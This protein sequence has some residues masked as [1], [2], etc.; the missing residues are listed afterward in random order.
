MEHKRVLILGKVWPEPNSSAAGRRMV[1]LITMLQEFGYEISF[2]TTAK[3]T[4]FHS[5]PEGIS[6][7]TIAVNDDNVD[8]WLRTLNPEIVIFDRFMTEEQFGWRVMEVLPDALRILNTEDLHFLR[9]AREK[10]IKQ[11]V[12]FENID[13]YTDK[14]KREIAAIYRCD[15]TLM[16]SE[17]EIE[18]LTNTFRIDPSLF[19]YLPLF[20]EYKNERLSFEERKGFVFI[21]N[22][23]HTP[24]WDALQYLKA[25][26]WPLIRAKDKTAV[27][28][29]YGAYPSEKV[30]Q[31][32]KPQEGFYVEGRA[33]DAREVIENARVMLAPIR[34][35]AGMKGKLLEAMELGTPSIVTPIAAEDMNSENR[36]NG[37]ITSDP[38]RLAQEAV[39]LY[40]DKDRW[41]QSQKTGEELIK[42]RYS[43]AIYKDTFRIELE[44]LLA[45]YKEYRKEN[46]MGQLI[47]HHSL[48]STKYLSRWIVEK[49]KN[50]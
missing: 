40:H 7:H 21:G 41:E 46:F 30:T 26:I 9:E 42:M 35:G 31:L 17:T 49:N 10:C 39:E 20:G 45:N 44:T 4:G 50:D 36:W 27:I 23:L 11:N 14:A 43:A 6:Y 28:H 12:H 22:F 15:K 19:I 24:N 16:V 48:L 38:E 2:A 13:L 1:Q 29:I 37:V 25:V 18:L 8:D 34:F 3:K 47:Q 33:E 5:E 32:S